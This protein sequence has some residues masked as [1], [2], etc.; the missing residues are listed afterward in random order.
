MIKIN[1]Q[2]FQAEI[3]VSLWLMQNYN[4]HLF[5]MK[6]TINYYELEM[7]RGEEREARVEE[8]ENKIV[9]YREEKE[10]DLM[11]IEYAFCY[12]VIWP[13]RLGSLK[14]KGEAEMP[15]SRRGICRLHS[16]RRGPRIWPLRGTIWPPFARWNDHC[17]FLDYHLK[18]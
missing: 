9:V 2:D 14:R 7:Q 10:R 16:L 13:G 8:L 3:Q 18:Y 15:S 12:L 17:I 6:E 1:N 11:V 5:Q 4:H